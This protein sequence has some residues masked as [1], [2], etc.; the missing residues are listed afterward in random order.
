MPFS[1]HQRRKRSKSTRALRKKRSNTSRKK[2]SMTSRKYRSQAWRQQALK[3]T[4]LNGTQQTETEESN[5]KLKQDLIEE[6][7]SMLTKISR[8]DDMT[9]DEKNEMLDPLKKK[10]NEIERTESIEWLKNFISELEKSYLEGKTVFTT[11]G[12]TL[13]FEPV[14]ANVF[15]VKNGQKYEGELRDLLTKMMFYSLA[16]EIFLQITHPGE[17]KVFEGKRVLGRRVQLSAFAEEH[18][19]NKEPTAADVMS[20]LREDIQ[21]LGI[22]SQKE[23][24]EYQIQIFDSHIGR[25]PEFQTQTLLIANNMLL[26]QVEPDVLVRVYKVLRGENTDNEKK[27]L[28]IF[29]EMFNEMFEALKHVLRT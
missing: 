26:L 19:Q 20:V 5:E 4:S 17:K 14:L 11:K 21:K 12:F 23:I 15:K 16:E 10:Y 6:Y 28:E 8:R 22:P 24:V 18:P 7:S 27:L 3:L 29:N 2:R 1:R 9:P 25:L 13:I